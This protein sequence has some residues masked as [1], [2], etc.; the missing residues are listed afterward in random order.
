MLY[1]V[2]G[3]LCS[4]MVSIVLKA[5][6]KDIRNVADLRTLKLASR[7]ELEVWRNQ[8]TVILTVEKD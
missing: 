1:L 4:A 3:L 6:G 7:F 5:G 2:A 8:Q